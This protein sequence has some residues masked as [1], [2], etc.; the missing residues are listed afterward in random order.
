M[1][2]L[3]IKTESQQIEKCG[4]KATCLCTHTEEAETTNRR[5][6]EALPGERRKFLASDSNQSDTGNVS[7]LCPAP[8][9]IELKTGA[10]VSY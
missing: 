3:L 5:E 2:N 8:A 9:V 4:V 7:A 10:Q 6:L 1:T